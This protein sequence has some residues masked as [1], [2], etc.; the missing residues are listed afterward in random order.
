MA[1]EFGHEKL[2][3]YQKAVAFVA[4]TQDYLSQIPNGCA[5]RDHLERASE[6]MPDNIADGNGRRSEKER[7]RCFDVAYGSC[8][9]C[10][11]CLDICSARG[12]VASDR[13]ARGKDELCAITKMLVGLRRSPAPV[14]R[15][16]GAE[17]R[18]D[19]GNEEG[20]ARFRHENL[21][22]YQTAI[23][24]VR[25]VHL[26]VASHRLDARHSGQLDKASTGIVLNIAEGNGRFS[27]LDHCRFLDT[28]HRWALRA[29]SR[30]DVAVARRLVHPKE[31]AEG[32]NLVRR[33]VSMLI[34]LKSSVAYET[35]AEQ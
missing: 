29:A 16:S 24:F 25:W 35:E 32:K 10:A 7:A 9:E 26:F 5:V 22:V 30:L 1:R 8:L 21:D 18:T 13:V 27:V 19:R 2:R 34:P 14:V 33:I 17:Y 11:G 12:F 23:E 20:V 31:I 4:L 6:G 15:E 28:A 3:V